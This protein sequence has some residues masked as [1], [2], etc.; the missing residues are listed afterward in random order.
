MG[1]LLEDIDD[2][3]GSGRLPLLMS[4]MVVEEL[5]ESSILAQRQVPELSRFLLGETTLSV[6]RERPPAVQAKQSSHATLSIRLNPNAH[7]RS[8]AKDVVVN[9]VSSVHKDNPNTH[10]SGKNTGPR[11]RRPRPLWI[12]L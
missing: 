5:K 9:H 3:V 1:G 2:V 11:S 4:A 8:C 7:E 6:G 10:P 12:V